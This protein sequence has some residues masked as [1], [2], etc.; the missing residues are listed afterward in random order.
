MYSEHLSNSTVVREINENRSGQA[1]HQSSNRKK[2]TP[3]FI[4][5]EEQRIAKNFLQE[6]HVIL[7][8][9]DRVILDE[10]RS[11]IS[12]EAAQHLGIEVPISHDAFLNSIHEFVKPEGLNAL[13]LQVINRVN[14]LDWVRP[15]Y[16]SLAR[17][18][19]ERIV[20]NELVMQ[21]RLNLS[22][23]MPGD[24]S[25][26]LPVHAD[27]WDGDS[28]FEVVVWLPLVD[29]FM[30]K[31]MFFLRPE[32][33]SRHVSEFDRFQG[34]STEDLFNA[35]KPDLQWLEISYGEVLVFSLTLLHGNRINE[36]LETRWSMNCRFK[37]LFSPFADK[38][39]GEFFEPISIKPATRFG[40][41]YRLPDSFD[42]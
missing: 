22:I 5:D 15:A 37:S 12:V 38:R 6:G 30:T 29:C 10:L 2:I 3:T 8:V 21:R 23:Q 19:I 33:S 4:E 27:V 26:L 31:S 42:D 41:N 34:K 35:V 18:A 40:M 1:R 16:F 25:S 9:E 7:P 11:T 28:P 14:S 13:R 39:I 17:R 20:G 36:E 24:E 32:A